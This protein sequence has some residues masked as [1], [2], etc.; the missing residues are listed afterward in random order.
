MK[1]NIQQ[2]G[3]QRHSVRRAIH[4]PKEHAE[5]P[6]QAYLDISLFFA[7]RPSWNGDIH[8]KQRGH[9]L[10]EHVSMGKEDQSKEYK[11][12]SSQINQVSGSIDE[13]I[14]EILV[15]IQ[16]LRNH[17]RRQSQGKQSGVRKVYS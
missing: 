4:K 15:Q 8:C 16:A 11:R 7:W 9:R 12:E 6:T 17:I 2:R 13:R 1:E 14:P 10:K 3:E 5:T